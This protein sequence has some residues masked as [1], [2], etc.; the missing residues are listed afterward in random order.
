LSAR[1][2]SL[3]GVLGAQYLFLFGF[4]SAGHFFKRTLDDSFGGHE[5][6]PRHKVGPVIC[7]LKGMQ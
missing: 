4:R 1:I 2:A 5:E 6:P 7:S 3:T